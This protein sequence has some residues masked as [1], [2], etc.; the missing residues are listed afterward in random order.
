MI[1]RQCGERE[2][3]EMNSC[4]NNRMDFPGSFH[5][6]LIQLY[7]PRVKLRLVGNKHQ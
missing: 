7:D 4:V 3:E 1:L 2:K 6:K 5:I